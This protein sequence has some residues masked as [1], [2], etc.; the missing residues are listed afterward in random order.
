MDA[1]LM[2]Q[3]DHARALLVRLRPLFEGGVT[4]LAQACAPDGKLDGTRLDEQQ[5]ATFEIAWASADLLAAETALERL[6]AGGDHEGDGARV[7]GQNAERHVG[8]FGTGTP[9]DLWM[10]RHALNGADIDSVL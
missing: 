9:Q 6:D 5:V 10:R 1:A 7:V 8:V 2:Q 3:R 4:A